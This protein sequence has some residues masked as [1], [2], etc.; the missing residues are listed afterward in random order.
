MSEKAEEAELLNARVGEVGATR[1]AGARGEVT[2]SVCPPD[3][4]RARVTAPI[5]PGMAGAGRGG[6]CAWEGD[7]E[8]DHACDMEWW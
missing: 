5:A 1:G 6:R 2:E 7:V 8:A 4:V 3:A